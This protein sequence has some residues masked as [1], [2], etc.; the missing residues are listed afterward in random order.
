MYLIQPM[1]PTEAECRD[2]LEKKTDGSTELQKGAAYIKANKNGKFCIAMR[3]QGKE[4][5]YKN[6]YCCYNKRNRDNQRT[7]TNNRNKK[8]N[9]HSGTGVTYIGAQQLISR[10]P[11]EK[12]YDK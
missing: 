9:F 6:R 8:N 4:I 10:T 1:N 2:N 7:K 3:T 12:I 11:Q 5:L